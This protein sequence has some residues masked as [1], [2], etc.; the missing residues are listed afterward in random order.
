MNTAT[1][2]GASR[3][4]LPVTL[5]S[6]LL[7]RAQKVILVV[8]DDEGM[9]TAVS[10]I[11]S[12]KYRVTLAVDGIDGC[13]KASVRPWPDLVIADISMPRLDGIAMVRRIWE[14][15]APRQVPVIFLTGQMSPSN[16][17]AGLPAGSCAYL[18]KPTDS[19]VLEMKV[20]RVLRGP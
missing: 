16:L 10:A 13:E 12:Q 15:Q 19:A 2:P 11:L 6:Q 5:P 8:D 4:A 7:T 14:S 20:E 17:M 3:V 9:R 18:S 1:I